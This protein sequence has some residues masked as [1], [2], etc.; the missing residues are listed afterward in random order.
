MVGTKNVGKTSIFNRYV[1]DDFTQT[2]MTLGAYFGLKTCSVNDRAV[3]L[4]IWDTAGEE[5]F[6]SMTSFYCR[7]AAAALIVYDITRYETFQK[8]NHW[9]QKVRKE[10]DPDCCIIVVGNKFDMVEERPEMRQVQEAEARRYAQS[11]DAGFMEVSAKSGKNVAMVFSTLA[12]LCLEKMTRAAAASRQQQLQNSQSEG[13]AQQA[14]TVD[15][16]NKQK[17][18]EG[19][20]CCK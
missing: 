14:G 18:G 3:N 11:I 8:L 16:R 19:G 5:K 7:N 1:Y 6:D 17:T 2:Q 9:V 12:S 15:L 20:G 10:A 13:N 4:A